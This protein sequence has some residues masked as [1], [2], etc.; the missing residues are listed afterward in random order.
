MPEE[1]DEFQKIFDA[2]FDALQKNGVPGPV[3]EFLAHLN[4]RLH[5]VEKLIRLRAEFEGGQHEPWCPADDTC[6]CDGKPLNDLV[7]EI[8]RTYEAN[9]P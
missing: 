2:Q 3:A 4:R 1:K 8:C 5:A 9:K 7:N 6:H